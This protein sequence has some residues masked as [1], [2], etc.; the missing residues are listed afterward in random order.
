MKLITG[1]NLRK[2]SII[3]IIETKFIHFV[4]I[5]HNK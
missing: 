1:F 3:F 2:L 4:K 5:M